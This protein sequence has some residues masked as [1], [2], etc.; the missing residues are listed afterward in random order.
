[1]E[2]I[3][4]HAVSTGLGLTP[5]EHPPSKNTYAP[6][7]PK[8][9]YGFVGDV[10]LYANTRLLHGRTTFKSF[11]GRARKLEGCYFDWDIVRSK[12]RVL[13]DRLNLPENQP[14]A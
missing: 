8:N 11:S 4:A 14:S 2:L 13:R 3:S 1:M 10:V 12:V 5:L 6:N 9:T 7:T